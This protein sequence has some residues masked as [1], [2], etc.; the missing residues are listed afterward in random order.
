MATGGASGGSTSR[1]GRGG[2]AGPTGRTG[3]A[4]TDYPKP[5]I[6]DPPPDVESDPED[7]GATVHLRARRRRDYEDDCRNNRV[8]TQQNFFKKIN[9][10][11]PKIKRNQSKPL[12]F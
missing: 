3:R 2:T 4:V 5:T 10:I 1:T 6:R 8:S 12:F 11:P 9:T 7:Y